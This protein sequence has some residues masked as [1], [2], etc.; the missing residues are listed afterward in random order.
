MLISGMKRRLFNLVA[1]VSLA[2]CGMFIVGWLAAGLGSQYRMRGYLAQRV[3][4]IGFERSVLACNTV[5]A[6]E[7]VRP[8]SWPRSGW[9]TSHYDDDEPGFGYPSHYTTDPAR[10]LWLHFG[11]LH[12]S[13][14]KYVGALTGTLNGWS[15]SVPSWLPT[16]LSAMV[17]AMWVRSVLR[18][19]RAAASERTGKCLNCGYD[20]RAT[21]NRCPECGTP[22]TS[23]GQASVASKPAEAAA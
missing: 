16:A 20:L 8:A 11:G 15:F 7:A 22:S 18:R 2:L 17:P 21:P 5:N 19:R 10:R 3:V 9:Y 1:A 12:V 14:F 23:S 13:E 6:A 4:Y